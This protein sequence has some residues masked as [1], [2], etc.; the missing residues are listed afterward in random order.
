[1]EQNIFL[2][3]PSPGPSDG[4]YASDA[5]DAP[6]RTQQARTRRP[7]DQMARQS[8]SQQVQE[9]DG[10]QIR[11][12]VQED[13][14][15]SMPQTAPPQE[16]PGAAVAPPMAYAAQQAA[17]QQAESD[18]MDS[19][20]QTRKADVVQVRIEPFA[21]VVLPQGD[22]DVVFGGQIYFL[23]HIQIEQKHFVQG[24]RL[25]QGR[26]VEQVK[27]S[28]SRLVRRGMGFTVGTQESPDAVHTAI[29]DFGFGTLALNLMELEPLWV[30]RDISRLRNWYLGIIVVVF[31][32]TTLAMTG[33]WLSVRTQLQLAKKKDDFISAVSHELRTPLTSI[34]MYTEMLEKGWVKGDDKRHEYY[35]TMRQETERLTRLVENVLDFARIQRGRKKYDF[36]IGDVNRVVRDVI[37]MMTPCSQQAGFAIR[38]E[39]GE[40][41]QFAFDADAVMQIVINLVDNALKYARQAAEKVICVRTRTEGGYVVIEVEDRGPGVPRVQRKKV[42]EEFYRIGD[43]SRRETTGTG[44]GLALVKH[45]SQAHNGFVEILSARP[46]GALF[47]VGL[48]L[49][50]A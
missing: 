13:P 36:R 20:T 21:P 34:R 8:P 5:R 49:R 25:H 47:R 30:A 38:T 41:P 46:T 29:L 28:A 3:A 43:E 48:A 12:E 26:L 33:L 37:E 35:G 14:V 22:G 10:R 17:V 45:L 4:V 9:A 23:R 50:T 1:V 7:R 24:F 32:A 2:N 44:L 15:L 11:G 40:T 31:A 6:S 18:R 19:M 42:F 27:D 39:L 16:Q